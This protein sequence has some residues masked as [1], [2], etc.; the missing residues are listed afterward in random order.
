[1]NKILRI[2][3]ALA[4][5]SLGVFATFSPAQAHSDELKT[6]PEA[7]STVEAGLIPVE[8]QFGE[9]LMVM[10][11]SAAS[12]EIIVVNAAGE[13]VAMSKCSE[14]KDSTLSATAMIADAGTYTVN[15]RAVSEDGHPVE[16]TF[17]FKVENTTGYTAETMAVA[18]ATP[19]PLIAPAPAED[20]ARNAIT[21]D[22]SAQWPIFASIAFVVLAGGVGAAVMVRAKRRK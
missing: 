4:L 10:A 13:P 9:P 2:S 8:L 21:D 20:M 15:W 19:M 6:S 1:M 12:N 16:G 11:D 3:L 22:A 18:C 17:D 5:S 14:A 7:G